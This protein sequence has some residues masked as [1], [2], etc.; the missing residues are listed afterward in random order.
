M[1]KI[2]ESKREIAVYLL[3]NLL[4]TCSMFFG[5]FAIVR[6]IGGRFTTA[7]FAIL[8]AS[9]FDALDGRVARMT[10]GTS[11]FG[12]EYDSLS[13]AISFGV[14]PA[15]LMFTWSLNTLGRFGWTACF[16]FLACGVLRLARFNV[17]KSGLE[18]N[19]FQGL[20]IPVASGAL[21]SSIL[22]FEEM[23]ITLEKNYYILVLM[24]LLA[25]LMVSNLRYK[26]FKNMEQ[27][28]KKSFLTLVSAI[29]ILVA[30]VQNLK[31][32]LFIFLM[33]YIILGILD[34]VLKRKKDKHVY[35]EIDTSEDTQNE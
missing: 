28:R 17:Q 20:P 25:A 12:E 14:A 15:V 10:G 6:A 11:V 4:T 32:N 33:I 1:N 35:D 2:I 22:F 23:N 26:N 18:K 31:I 24:F 19:Y 13:D 21:A 7:A 27:D 5:F 3:P 16:F 30:L 9:V 8:L 34:N 29:V